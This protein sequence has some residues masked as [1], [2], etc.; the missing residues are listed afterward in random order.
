MTADDRHGAETGPESAGSV[1]ETLIGY[2][3]KRAYVI[4][5]ADFRE[6]LGQDGLGPRAFSALS[7]V[8]QFPEITQS[9]LARKLGIERS[10][11]VAIVDDLER[12][13]FLRRTA[14]P[15]DR[16]SHALVATHVGQAA[17]RSAQD[18]V[19]AHEAALLAH[20]TE[21]EREMLI[22]LLRKIRAREG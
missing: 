15:G 6:A 4:V 21:Q 10:G 14:V 16:R 5:Q 19:R 7:F 22:T 18:A 20:M 1:L 17:L 11:L 3:L 9:A 13:G 8:V 12:R 2:N